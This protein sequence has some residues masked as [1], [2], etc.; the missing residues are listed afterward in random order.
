MSASNDLETKI[1][2]HVLGNTT[3][4]PAASLWLALFTGS[5]ASN[6]EANNIS[7]EVSTVGTD[8]AREQITFNAA[9]GNTASNAS[10]FSYNSATANYGTVTYVAVMDA[11]TSGNVVFYGEVSGGG[12][13]VNT[14]DTFQVSAGSIQVTLD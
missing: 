8:Y 2:D 14:G 6:L 3:Y 7:N 12:K 4:S 5:P 1:L 9:S 10:A 11:Q 13:V